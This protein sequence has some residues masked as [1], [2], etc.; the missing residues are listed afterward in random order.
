MINLVAAKTDENLFIDSLDRSGQLRQQALAGKRL[1]LRQSHQI[2]DG[3]RDI[4]MRY[5]RMVA[6]A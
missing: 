6:A 3:R 5:R 2:E 1:R 4:D